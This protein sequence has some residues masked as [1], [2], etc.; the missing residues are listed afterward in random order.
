VAVCKQLYDDWCNKLSLLKEGKTVN[1][2]KSEAEWTS[3]HKKAPME[4]RANNDEGVHF[5]NS[6]LD[7]ARGLK[8]LGKSVNGGPSDEY[9]KIRI[10][11]NKR[12]V[13]S[14]LIKDPSVKKG[15]TE[16]AAEAQPR[17]G[18]GGGCVNAGGFQ[19]EAEDVL[20]ANINVVG[21]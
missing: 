7:W 21:S 9:K 14:G 19:L 5:Y 1:M 20:P 16:V 3:D 17:S 12:C 8:K 15:V 18:G 13:E 10:E 6:C 2:N 11:M 4:S